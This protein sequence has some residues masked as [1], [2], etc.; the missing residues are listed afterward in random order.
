L[1]LLLVAAGGETASGQE[2][3]SKAVNSAPAASSDGK[4]AAEAAADE[5][6][7]V[8]TTTEGK[9]ADAP[10]TSAKPVA[11]PADR[12]S[13]ASPPKPPDKPSAAAPTLP[14][15]D[16][17]L[18][19]SFRL[20]P[21]QNV[22]DW[23]AEQAGLSLLMES[24]PPGTLNYTDN[25]S[26]TPAEALDVMNGVLL[27]KG[28]TLV[29]RGRMLV[30]VNL[31][32]GIPP[33]L[34]PDVSLSELDSRGEYELVRAIFPVWNM[35]PEQAAAEVQPLL[36]PQGKVVTLPQARQIQVT[37]TG[38]R[39]RTIRSIVNAVEQPDHG[40]AGMREFTLKYLTF[41]TAMPT[42]RQMLGIPAEAFSSPD[43]TVQ[44]TKSASGDKLLF[45]GNAQQA[46]RL[47]EVLRLVDVPEAARGIDGSPQLEVYPVT[48]ADPETVVKV[49]QVMLRSDPNVV[50]TA[51]KD[52][53]HVVAFAT[54]PQQATI[55]ATIDQMQKDAKH[56]DVI[57]LSNVDPQ[58]AVLAINKL[59]G[60]MG[61]EPDPKAPRV[62]ADITT[63]SAAEAG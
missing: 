32:D 2:S 59:F 11:V 43:G 29:R 40:T 39:L 17:R 42:I 20:E 26:Y 36:G 54:P 30:V 22:L 1:A 15:E 52:A 16:V 51:D 58:T 38:G 13:A 27:T 14:P 50:L 57:N 35:T 47:T 25:R 46:A 53:G 37:E 12:P 8:S 28:Y 34:V 33:N 45:R 3:E 61:D 31:E 62:D 56:V 55:K 24:V 48:T 7:V 19:F 41:D 5:K 4:P 6:P 9:P 63:R 10:A 60:S 49:L 23:F 18:Q 44:V 21:W